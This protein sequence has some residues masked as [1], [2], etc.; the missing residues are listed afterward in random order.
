LE[1]TTEIRQA[2]VRIELEDLVKLHSHKQY[3]L[4]A[5][6]ADAIKELASDIAVLPDLMR[7]LASFLLSADEILLW[8]TL[9]VLNDLVGVA[10]IAK[11]A[12]N[13]SEITKVGILTTVEALAE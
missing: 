11:A 2:I 4:H 9:L 7:K 5:K 13:V 3:S 12:A 6:A 1:G 10:D 8:T